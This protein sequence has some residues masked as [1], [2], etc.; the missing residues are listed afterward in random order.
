MKR[1]GFA[2]AVLMAVIPSAV[3]GAIAVTPANEVQ[4]RIIVRGGVIRLGSSV[5]LLDNATHASS[6]ITSVTLVNHCDLRVYTDRASGEEV[7]AAIAE[8]DETLARLQV[9]AGVSG[10]GGYAN[11][12]LYRRG[13]HICANNSIFGTNA[14]IWLTITYLGP[15]A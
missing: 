1:L 15:A 3:L 8:E 9:Q 6:G 2:L 12:Y 11:V 7:I 14:N 13:S 5:Y 10:G 4:D